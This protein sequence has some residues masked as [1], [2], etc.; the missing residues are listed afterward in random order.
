MEIQQ[1]IEELGKAFEDFKKAND[2]ELA[3]IKTKGQ[4]SGETKELTEKLQKQMD[5]LQKQIGQTAA[6]LN[7]TDRTEG[8]KTEEEV[9]MAKAQKAHSAALNS[10]L[11]KGNDNAIKAFAAEHKDMTVDSD[12]DGGFLVSTEMS[13]EIVKHVFESSPMR[14]LASVQ[15]ISSDALEMLEDLDQAGSGWVAERGSRSVT[16]TP[17]LNQIKIP[18]H[19]LYAEPKAT[20]KLL[21]DASI[22][23]ESWLAGKVSEKF[24]RDEATAFVS[25]S[26][27]GQPQGFLGGYGYSTEQIA[28]HF[29]KVLNIVQGATG[30]DSAIQFDDVFD[31]QTALKEAYQG[32]ASWLVH[33]SNLG[34]IRKLKDSYGRYLWEP[35]LQVAAPSM[36]LGRPIYTAADMVKSSDL[37]I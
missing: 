1:K 28:D 23:I 8:G 27:V 37:T 24:A 12:Q 3:E 11:R 32:N 22:N 20:Q 36:L 18:V 10:Y 25:G 17:K 35:G 9:K 5:E 15:T 29:G 14:A 31:M 30:H 2:K 16:T 34:A 6:L 19:E 13:S 26:G 21:D 4:A 33:R 7:R